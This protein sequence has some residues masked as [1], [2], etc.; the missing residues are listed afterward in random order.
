VETS[1]SV[2]TYRA[3]YVFSGIGPP[4]ANG[5]I[6]VADGRI[7]SVG[8]YT[9]G[10]RAI[11]L[12]DVALL[13]GLINAHTHLE[14]SDLAAPLG[15][16]GMAFPD[17]VRLLIETRRRPGPDPE[18][19]A[20]N[21]AEGIAESLRHGVAAVAE[22]AQPQWSPDPFE[23]CP[24]DT[25]AFLEMICLAPEGF[26]AR[27]AAAQ[28]HLQAPAPRAIRRGLSPHA[29]YSV[30]P[31]LFDRLVSL[32]E[33]QAA[34]MQF[35]LAESR[36]ELELLASGGGPFR[37]LLM[38]LGLWQPAAFRS[39]RRPLDYL[40]RLAA[41]KVRALAIHCNYLDDEEIALLA[42][43]SP[44]LV[45]VYCP[46]THA[47]FGHPRHPLP[48]LLAAGASVA[49]GTD[50]RASNPDLSVLEEL[51]FVARHFPEID[52]Q[53]VLELGTIR[54]ARALG[55]A[56]NLGSLEPSKLAR[57]AAVPLPQRAS[58]DPYELLYG[59]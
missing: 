55:I 43:H 40:R 22:I 28:R 23:T 7:V 11:D 44:R 26:D 46:R 29:P 30:H 54:A 4:L 20:K 14:F 38:E 45:A 8:P 51:R 41:G 52:P 18:T 3:Q 17:W 32:A 2:V 57:W 19:A 56:G 34:P 6:A 1:A 48:R 21:V 58:S 42:A 25:T 37:D 39:P 13:P 49:V 31:D 36:E 9:R 53:T 16:P 47:F 50:S 59:R 12:G 27:L 5:V 24:L 10:E 33:R 35:H 15:R